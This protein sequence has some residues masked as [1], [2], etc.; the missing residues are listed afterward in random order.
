MRAGYTFQN[1]HA[2][3]ETYGGTSGE[4]YVAY[5]NEEGS[6]TPF[7]SDLS[8]D[9]YDDSKLYAEWEANKIHVTLDP[10][11]G[12][13]G[14]KEFW[15]IFDTKAYFTDEDL[16]QSLVKIEHPTRT[17]YTFEG[18]GDKVSYNHS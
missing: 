14:T 10:N 7:A 17:G 9:V 4:K 16:T 6:F 8:T 5:Y 15:Y 1:Y 3:A 18:Y 2:G 13:G 12:T 11:K